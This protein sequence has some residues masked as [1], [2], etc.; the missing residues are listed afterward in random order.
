VPVYVSPIVQKIYRE[1]FKEFETKSWKENGGSLI[2]TFFDD[3]RTFAL[4][5]PMGITANEDLNED[6]MQHLHEGDCK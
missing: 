6:I 2:A 3:G 4:T 1:N 5:A